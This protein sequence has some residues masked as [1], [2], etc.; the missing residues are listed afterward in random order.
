M[1]YYW[2]FA[3]K[4][5]KLRAVETDDALSA[6]EFTAPSDSSGAETLPVGAI[7]KKT[8]L[9]T[10][11]G[12]QLA[13]YFAGKRRVFDLPIRLDGTEFQRR[14]WRA[15][16]E[17]PY[18]ATLS[19]GELARKI[20]QPNAARAVGRANNRNAICIVVPCHRVIGHDGRMVGYQP[21]VDKKVFL[22]E[23]ERRVAA[24]S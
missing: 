3:Q 10:E 2:T 16:L 15:L 21:G 17:I 19:Y 4:M 23:L 6:L 13:D 24:E 18:G 9:L 11:V 22:L 20:G 12:R 8:P 14:V 5:G 7:R 1:T